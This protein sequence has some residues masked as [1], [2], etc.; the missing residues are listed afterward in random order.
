MS[1][2]YTDFSGSFA[3]VYDRYLVERF[4]IINML[5]EGAQ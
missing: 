3:E 4:Q 2:P 1:A 5:Y